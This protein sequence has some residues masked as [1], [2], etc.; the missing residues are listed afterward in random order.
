VVGPASMR[1][2]LTG[3]PGGRVTVRECPDSFHVATLDNDAETIFAGSLKFI[4]DHSG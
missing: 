3:V 1:V 4:Q 2:L